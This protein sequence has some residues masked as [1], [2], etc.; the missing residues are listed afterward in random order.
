M[1]LYKEI[2]NHLMQI[3]LSA[4]TGGEKPVRLPSEQQLARKFGASRISVR[5]ALDDLEKQ[6]YLYKIK[7][8]GSF[9]SPK[10]TFPENF[11]FALILPTPKSNFNHDILR[12]VH[13]FCRSA[14]AD[15][16]TL[17]SW[18]SP[19]EER[20]CLELCFRLNVFN[21][22]LMPVDDP[23][24]ESYFRS[25]DPSV[26]HLVF[27][28]RRYRGNGYGLV[29]SD[30]FEIGYR[31]MK[32]LLEKGHKHVAFYLT[33]IQSSSVRER[34]RGYQKAQ[35][36]A[37]GKTDP[38]F[39][40]N[41]ANGDDGES[42]SAYLAGKPEI[43]ALISIAGDPANLAIRAAESL[44]KVIGADFDLFVID[45]ETFS[46]YKTNQSIPVIIQDGARMGL[47]AANELFRRAT[48]GAPPQDVL[49]PFRF[50][51]R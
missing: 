44:G 7:G 43:S 17:Y 42:L 37:F 45:D 36:E 34:I 10:K 11:R 23:A 14:G 25:L 38:C 15:F 29:A 35:L 9:A 50:E 40:L 33:T 8:K 26:L 24:N 28:D 46:D 39:V 20:R 5:H 19:G 32:F 27:L 1:L 2:E 4:D 31:A 16:I 49:I 6:G 41:A 51:F 22:L 47:V 12:G 18:Q 48:S 21:V 13:C 3:I 30:N